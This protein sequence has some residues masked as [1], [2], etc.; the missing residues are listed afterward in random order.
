MQQIIR[1]EKVAKFAEEELINSQ[2]EEKG[3][4]RKATAMLAL[5]SELPLAVSLSTLNIDVN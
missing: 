4:K 3:R 2:Q 5:V 1:A